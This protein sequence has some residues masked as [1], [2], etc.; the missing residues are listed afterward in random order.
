MNI[1]L[2]TCVL[3]ELRHPKGDPSIREAVYKFEDKS[4]FI[5]VITLGEISKGISL[6]EDEHSVYNY[7]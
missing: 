3:A 2:D 5:S 4:L 7:S 6:L 1:L